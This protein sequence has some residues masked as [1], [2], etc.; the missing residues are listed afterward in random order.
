MALR[1]PN[2]PAVSSR[3]RFLSFAFVND[4][5]N[6]GGT[7]ARAKAEKATPEPQ[8]SIGSADFEVSPSIHSIFICTGLNCLG[9]SPEA[10]RTARCRYGCVDSASSLYL[11][12]GLRR[13]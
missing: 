5:L 1:N 9:A 6:F 4:E 11:L 2:S 3:H 7:Y 13:F 8:H 10:V 12:C